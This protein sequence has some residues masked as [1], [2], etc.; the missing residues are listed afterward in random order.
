MCIQPAA[1]QGFIGREDQVGLGE[2][3]RILA[4]LAV[5]VAS[6]HLLAERVEQVIE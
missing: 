2:F 3:F 5:L 4:F 6:D 1:R